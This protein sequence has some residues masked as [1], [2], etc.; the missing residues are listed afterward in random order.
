L[1]RIVEQNDEILALEFHVDYWDTL[2]YGTAGQWKD[3]FSSPHYSKRQRDYN[4]LNLD[5]RIG[6]Y[7]P[8]MIVNGTYAFVGSQSSRAQRQMNQQSDFPLTASAE[9][10]EEGRLTVR[11]DGDYAES[12]DVWLVQFDQRHVTEISSGENKGKTLTNSNIV[13]NL[14]SLGKWRG[15]SLVI[16]SDLEP[17]G[18]N[19]A[20]AIIVQAYSGSKDR[21]DGPVLGAAKCAPA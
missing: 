7:T 19:Q 21:I 12:A 4:R 13:R 6:V 14:Q 3:P 10:S 2:V 8:Q 15:Q 18:A 17:L 1:G 16:H 5:G 20:C 9:V 11:V